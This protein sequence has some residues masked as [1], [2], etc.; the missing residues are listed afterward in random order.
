MMKFSKKILSLAVIVLLAN[1]CTEMLDEPPYS[2]LA[3]QN[4]LTT[5]KGLEATLALAYT[6]SANM[7]GM[8]SQ[9]DIKREEM[10][11]D[12]LFHS[13]GG[14]HG[15]ASLLINFSWD[16][17]SNVGNAFMW[18]NYWDA[19]RNANIVIENVQNV[20]EISEGEKAGYKAEARFLRA[21]SYYRLWNQYGTVPLRVSTTEQP[22]EIPRATEEEF[23][24]FMESELLAVIPVLPEPGKELNY[25][26]AHKGAARALLTKWY[27]NTYQW[28]KSADM[29]LEIM[30]IGHFQLYP[31]YNDMFAL[32]NERNSEFIWV[33]P[34]TSE[35][36]G[37]RNVTTAT[38]L[39]WGFE[40]A[41]DS[42][43]SGLK[44]QGWAN[45]ASQYRLYDA[46]YNSFE[47]EDERDDRILTLYLNNKGDTVDL[48]EDFDNATR[49]LK[50]P[51]DPGAT[52]PQHSNDIPF[53]RYADILLARAEALNELNGPNTES[54]GLVNRIRAR[55]G[56]EDIEL[57]DFNSKESLRDHILQER[58]WEFWYEGKRRRDLIRMGKFIEFAHQRGVTNADAHHK[59][60]PLP[61]YAIDANPLLVQNPGY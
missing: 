26:R 13:G 14:E 43:I 45:F 40:K 60:F 32:E 48:L 24:N 52:G 38:A 20:E 17:S 25:G 27:L 22:L 2:E 15:T 1:G 59:W 10:T 21:Y 61:Q 3:P 49:G 51:P 41:L 28:Q 39:P 12:I 31:D 55:A 37:A 29:A 36:N 57:S 56:L 35:D 47:P 46:F 16:A 58:G 50:Y 34:A 53:I 6:R 19:I 9:H 44:M 23:K 4:F 7:Q 30:D 18:V 11:T 8:Q 42:E 33:K 5:Q 54:I